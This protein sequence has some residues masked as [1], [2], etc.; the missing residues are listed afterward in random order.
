MRHPERLNAEVATTLKQILSRDP[1]LNRLAEHVRS[2]AVMMTELG[3]GRL[4]EW[5]AMV[6]IDTLPALA[7]FARNLRRD[8]DAVRNG[9]T[10]AYNSGPVEG[11]NNR[12]KMLKRQMY[13]RAN[14]DLLCKRVLFAR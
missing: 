5:I 12:V 9:L 4:E 1:E 10:L 6:E 8:L 7:S 13:G 3:G 14:L 2:F 11:N